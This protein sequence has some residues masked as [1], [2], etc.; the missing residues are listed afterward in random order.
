MRQCFSCS[1][2]PCIMWVPLTPLYIYLP[3]P[4][5]FM[6]FILICKESQRYYSLIFYIGKV[7]NIFQES[8]TCQGE[9]SNDDV[10]HSS[11]TR[12][13]RGNPNIKAFVSMIREQVRIL[14]YNLQ[15]FCLC[16]MHNFS[17]VSPMMILEAHTNTQ[18]HSPVHQ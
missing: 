6:Y 12:T 3:Y 14:V 8:K 4:I 18:K 15:H 13:L 2:L 11:R 16:L 10:I 7:N 5:H 17:Y 9:L 1:L